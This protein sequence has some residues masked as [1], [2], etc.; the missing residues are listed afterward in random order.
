MI[1]FSTL[2]SMAAPLPED[3]IDTDVIF[4]ARFLLLLDKAGLGRHVF[5]DRRFGSGD[6]RSD[7]IL[8]QPHYRSACILV[9]GRNFGCGSSREQAAWALSD[10]GIKC[11]VA[12]SFGEIFHANCFNNGILPI[13]L[14]AD[15]HARVLR[16]ADAGQVLTVDLERQTICSAIGD[17]IAFAVD[18]HRRRSLLLGLD[19][20]GV[21]LAEDAGD[22][23]RFER[24]HR[25]RHPW[26]HL[27]E[28]RAPAIRSKDGW[29]S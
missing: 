29:L 23:A 7:F 1:A 8:D 20:I 5:H 25:A 3:D 18:P 14:A 17:P 10:F 9:A 21:I 26:L 4:P 16:A 11:V 19:E 28:A 2:T 13:A 12:L 24:L 6:A 27:D 15:L 22:I